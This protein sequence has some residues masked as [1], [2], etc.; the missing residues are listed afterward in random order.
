MQGCERISIKQNVEADGTLFVMEQGREV[1]F[2]I[3]RIFFV[4]RVAPGASRGDHATKETRLI[5]FPVAGECDVVVDNGTE[6]ETY[7]MDD[8]AQGL[9]IAPMIW[10]S[11]RHFTPDCVMM[12]VCDRPFAPGNETYDDYSAYLQ[13]LNEKGVATR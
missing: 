2:P 13:A 4:S 5:L 8:P 7:H 11:M 12:A 6:Q 1:P 9:M 10:R 3:Q